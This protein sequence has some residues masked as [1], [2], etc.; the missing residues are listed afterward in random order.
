[1][2]L[3]L[4]SFLLFLNLS[5]SKTPNFYP[6]F[7]A[8]KEASKNSQKDL[9]IFFSKTGCSEC[10]SAWSAYEKD[11]LATKIFI[12][13]MVDAKD[14]DGAV[15][16]DK[17]GLNDAPSWVILDYQGTMKQKWTGEWKNPHVRPTTPVVQETKVETPPIKE[18]KA[19]TAAQKP[20]TVATSNTTTS[21]TTLNKEAPVVPVESA[22]VATTEKTTPPS[23]Q[24]I[25]NPIVNTP[26]SGFVLQAG[27]FGSETNAMKLVK[28]LES[29]GFKDYT[30][31]STNQN[32]SLFY[33]VISAVYTSEAEANKIIQALANTGVKATV[34]KTTEI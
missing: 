6:S 26:I 11:Q 19:T 24:P 16:L 5:G 10:E 20:Q 7:L 21:V 33:R 3:T 15:I 1:M 32:G 23:A 2:N 8:A 34:K 4:L 31:K 12:S 14:F 25:D 29:K 27:Y 13:T 17:Y 30:V 28:D 18:F 9:L 22:I